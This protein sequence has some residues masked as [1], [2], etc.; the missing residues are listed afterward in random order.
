MGVEEPVQR[1]RRRAL[2]PP[3]PARARPPR[4]ALTPPTRVCREVTAAV[5]RRGR[6]PAPPTSG[7]PSAAGNA[8]SVPVRPLLVT[9]PRPRPSPPPRLL[10]AP[11]RR[12]SA[13]RRR[14]RRRQN[15]SDALRCE[16]RRAPGGGGPSPDPRQACWPPLGARTRVEA[17]RACA[18]RPGPEVGGGPAVHSALGR[19]G[20]SRGAA[21]S[22]SAPRPAGRRRRARVGHRLAEEAAATPRGSFPEALERGGGD[23]ER[24]LSARWCGGRGM[25]RC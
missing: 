4:R 18:Q 5:L 10:A 11:V 8:S 17:S 7:A 9:S 23:R 2:A 12:P 13:R 6:T 20:P 22:R 14:R 3:T 25:A 15:V 21:T 1:R 16:A 19:C 24:S